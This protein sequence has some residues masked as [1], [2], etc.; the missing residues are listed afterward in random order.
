MSARNSPGSPRPR[1]L[2]DSAKTTVGPGGQ[3][4]IGVAHA[5]GEALWNPLRE[6]QPAHSPTTQT[7][8]H[9]DFWYNSREAGGGGGAEFS[10]R[11]IR[12]PLVE[13]SRL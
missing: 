9:R 5:L 8:M 1:V 7:H 4:Q 3:R 2:G 11:D 10:Q 6:P 12:W 13:Q